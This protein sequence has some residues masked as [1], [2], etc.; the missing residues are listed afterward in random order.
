MYNSTN[1][2]LD[3]L[4]YMNKR[5][6]LDK[7]CISTPS[8]SPSASP[9]SPLPINHDFTE[10]F[11]LIQKLELYKNE[12][13]TRTKGELA[14]KIFY[15]NTISLLIEPNDKISPE[16]YSIDQIYNLNNILLIP[17]K[18]LMLRKSLESNLRDTILASICELVER[19]SLKIINCWSLIFHCL[20]RVILDEKVEKYF[21]KNLDTNQSDS[22]VYSSEDETG[23]KSSGS[24]SSSDR[25][26]TKSSFILPSVPFR[27][28]SY[29]I[30]LNSLKEVFKIFLSL[31]QDSEYIMAFGAFEFLKCVSNYLQYTTSL[32]FSDKIH[33]HKVEKS[34]QN[35][36]NLS[37]DQENEDLFLSANDYS[38]QERHYHFTSNY[39]HLCELSNATNSNTQNEPFIKCIRKMFDIIL[40]CKQSNDSS[41]FSIQIKNFEISTF[42]KKSNFDLENLKQFF[43]SEEIGQLIYAEDQDQIDGLNFEILMA[44][45]E[46]NSVQIVQL[47]FDLASELV[48][49]NEL[50]TIGYVILDVFLEEISLQIDLCELKNSLRRLRR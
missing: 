13:N 42:E 26:F 15:T 29:R 44:H 9:A 35:D 1:L 12:L 45:D 14:S 5:V 36:E 27:F 48:Q 3:Y 30:R 32:D 22:S 40:K 43:A 4:Q 46:I 19:S 41:K 39:E 24:S 16:I 11:H 18:R 31:A 49:N 2:T 38:I 8:I 6:S 25:C 28:E 21:P 17:Y 50:D 34:D 37:S 33:V 20:S 7:K 23:Q 10:P 47:M